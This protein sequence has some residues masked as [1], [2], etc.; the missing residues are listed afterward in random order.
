VS[1]V[2]SPLPVSYCTPPPRNPT[3]T[4]TGSCE[5]IASRCC[6]RTE[7]VHPMT[8][9]WP[10]AISDENGAHSP[11]GPC[12]PLSLTIWARRK[13]RWRRRR[14]PEEGVEGDDERMQV[15]EITGARG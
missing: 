14:R 9:R 4:T 1:S 8:S 3:S 11:R 12:A 5:R 13:D 2:A 7:P 6:P 10:P 15:R